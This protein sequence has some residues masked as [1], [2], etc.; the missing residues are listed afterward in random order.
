L[1]TKLKNATF[2]LNT[3]TENLK[4]L[5]E[6]IVPQTQSSLD[7]NSVKLEN[8]IVRSPI[9]GVVSARN[10]SAGE[11]VNS[12]TRAL[13]VID[14]SILIANVGIPY[15]MVDKIQKGQKVQM[16]LGNDDNRKFEGI[17]DAISPSTDNTSQTYFIRIKID[18]KN[19]ALRSGAFIRVFLPAEKK[20]SVLTVPN[21]AILIENGIRYIFVV[22]EG[23][24]KKKSVNVGLSN[25]K[26]SEITS[27]LK[28]GDLVI[29]EGQIFI[30]DGQ[31]VNIVNAD[32]TA[33]SGQKQNKPEGSN[34]QGQT[35][36]KK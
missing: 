10:I 2:D 14:T 6:K 25:D 34:Q 3:A 20:D 19:N 23:K 5:K 7:S 18:N 31:R 12:S 22:E 24:V 4:I 8:S 29:T 28:E 36:G 1:Q 21:Q 11:V 30:N 16:K 17:V 35:S 15:K 9:S 33:N 27:S 32:G 26:V 13:T